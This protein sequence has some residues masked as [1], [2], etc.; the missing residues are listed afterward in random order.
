MADRKAGIPPPGR[1]GVSP[2][3]PIG[4]TPA[5]AKFEGAHGT[6]KIENLLVRRMRKRMM[7]LRY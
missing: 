7:A 1:G 4:G 3:V 5:D 2:D 6:R